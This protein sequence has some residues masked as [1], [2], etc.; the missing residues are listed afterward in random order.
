MKKF[1]FILLFICVIGIVVTAYAYKDRGINNTDVIDLDISKMRG[2]LAYSQVMNIYQSPDEYIGKRIKING[3]YYGL[4]NDETDLY[5][6][7]VVVGDETFCCQIGM[8]FVWNGKHAYPDDYPK[9]K[10]R[11]E[12]VGVF[13][14]Y[15]KLG[16]TYYFLTVEDI[17]S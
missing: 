13:G 14:S 3:L 1:L 12:L 5:S 16:K 7:Y 15:N 11:I 17:L 4:H 10:A 9:E 6:H 8:E 2:V